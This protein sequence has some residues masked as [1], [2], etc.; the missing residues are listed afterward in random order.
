MRSTR[1][2]ILSLIVFVIV[3]KLM[4]SAAVSSRAVAQGCFGPANQ[5]NQIGEIGHPVNLNF[6]K[7]W[8]CLVET[9]IHRSHA[10]NWRLKRYAVIL[11]SGHPPI[12]PSLLLKSGEAD[13]ARLPTC[14]KYRST[15]FSWLPAST[16]TPFNLPCVSFLLCNKVAFRIRILMIIKTKKI[17]ID[18]SV[19]KNLC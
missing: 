15:A 7:P 11:W 5:N 6:F 1:H 8:L 4:V 14:S 16:H 17:T 9:K 3:A 19:L 2:N 13:Y 18:H 10:Q 12:V